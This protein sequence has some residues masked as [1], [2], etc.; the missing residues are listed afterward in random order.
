F[1][2]SVV[3]RC[4]GDDTLGVAPRENSSVPGFL[5]LLQKTLLKYS[6]EFFILQYGDIW[7]KF[8]IM[9]SVALCFSERVVAINGL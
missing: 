1:P 9:C 2:N 7:V 3:K 4:C 8:W 6:E 5:F